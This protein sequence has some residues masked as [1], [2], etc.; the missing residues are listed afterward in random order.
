MSSSLL[1]GILI[2]ITI[3]I[4]GSFLCNNI[5]IKKEKS[6]KQKNNLKI[7]DWLRYLNESTSEYKR[8]LYR[9]F[10]D[11]EW[12]KQNGW[13]GNDLIHSATSNAVYISHYFYSSTSKQLIGIVHFGPNAESHRGFCHGG[14]MTSCFDDVLGHIAFM[15]GKQPWCGCTAQVDCTLKM[16]VKVGQI[17]KI[18]AT[19]TKQERRKLY[20]EGSL[21]DEQGNVY[22]LLKGL[23]ISDVYFGDHDDQVSKRT[24]MEDHTTATNNN[25]PAV[26]KDTGWLM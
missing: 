21:E 18:T 7:P 23:S 8:V 16:P 24:W 22:A 20:V 15:V 9:E 11:I 26:I 1:H 19:I 3:T 4:T 2:G 5:L 12:R 6:K 10:E 13:Y 25:S 14:A 17:L